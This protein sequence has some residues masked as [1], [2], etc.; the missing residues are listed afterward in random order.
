MARIPGR[1][2]SA[3]VK[4]RS[5]ELLALGERREDEVA[6]LHGAVVALELDGAGLVL[7]GVEG[8]ARE[9]VDYALFVELFV[10]ESGGDFAI[11]FRDDGRRS[12][13]RHDVALPK[14]GFIARQ[15]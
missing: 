13:S 11:Q 6:E 3:A 14:G 2:G 7:V 8:D 12:S 5:H 4:S 1:L 9:T 15:A 10:I